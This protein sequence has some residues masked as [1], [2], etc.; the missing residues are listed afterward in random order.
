MAR[1]AGAAVHRA[2]DRRVS[3]TRL[4]SSRQIFL[5]NALADEH[6]GLEAVDDGIWNILFYNTLLGR[7]D[8]DANAISGA[9]LMSS[10][11]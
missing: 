3:A 6:I 2:R 7:Y 11:N 5:S 10:K 8:A 1:R 9:D 4:L